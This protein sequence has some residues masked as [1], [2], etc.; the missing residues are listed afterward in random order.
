MRALDT[1][2]SGRLGEDHV[3]D[4]SGYGAVAESALTAR[5]DEIRASNG[6]QADVLAERDSELA[7]HV[8]TMRMVK[9]DWEVDQMQQAVD[10]TRVGFD[11]VIEELPTVVERGRGE[12]WVEGIFG[13]H[14]RHQGNGVGYDSICASGDHANTLHWIK[15]TGDIAQD[16]LLLLDAGVEVDS[17]FTADITRTLPVSGT[18]SPTQR[19]VHEA[20][21]AAQAAGIA[22]VKPGNKFS[23]VHAAA[24][25]VVAEHRHPAAASSTIGVA[26]AAHRRGGRGALRRG[27]ARRA[28]RRRGGRGRPRA[29]PPE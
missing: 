8:S 14:A 16:E 6:A 20:V 19:E 11:A 26:R 22:A 1:G 15:N 17:L 5:V 9:D 18:F 3:V 29:G 21:A 13:L 12:R 2:W 7:H 4:L 27:G 25:R 28:P 10:A 24:I 23:D